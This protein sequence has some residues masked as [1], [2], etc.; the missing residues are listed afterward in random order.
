[1]KNIPLA[2][3][4]MEQIRNEPDKFDMSTWVSTANSLVPDSEISIENMDCGTTA[5][6]AGWACIL[7]GD[8]I[9]VNEHYRMVCGP[10][11]ARISDR[12]A[13]LLGLNQREAH[14]LFQETSNSYI[15]IAVEEIF[16]ERL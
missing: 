9:S 12:A 6:F 10:D 14:E 1:M 8:T 11:R 13:E 2:R 3:K 4:V 16:G 15:D 5:C 7:N